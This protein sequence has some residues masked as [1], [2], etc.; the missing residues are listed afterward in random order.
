MPST[1]RGFAALLPFKKDS[2]DQNNKIVYRNSK[3]FYVVYR[4]PFSSYLY[5]GRNRCKNPPWTGPHGRSLEQLVAKGLQRGVQE[6]L[7]A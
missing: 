1:W 2:N 4:V 7:E 3:G 6:L 5:S